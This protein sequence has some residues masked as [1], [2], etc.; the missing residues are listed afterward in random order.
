[1]GAG[2]KD[3]KFIRMTELLGAVG[4]GKNSRSE[5]REACRLQKVAGAATA[6]SE[7]KR[8]NRPA[9]GVEQVDILVIKIDRD[10]VA[11]PS[12]VFAVAFGHDLPSFRVDVDHC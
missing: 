8:S 2:A 6:F 10:P 11:G 7:L 5:F 3:P 4:K 1:L 12:L 9:V